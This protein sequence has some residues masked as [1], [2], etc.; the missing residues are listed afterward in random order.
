MLPHGI[1]KTRNGVA[2]I[3]SM[4]DTNGLPTLL[5]YGVYVGEVVVPIL[6]IIGL[7]T[8]FS[9]LIFAVNMAVA[10]GLAHAGDLLSLNEHG[11]WAVELPMLYL[12]GAV[13]ILFLGPGRIAAGPKRGLLA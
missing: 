7:L 1:A 4:L 11:G 5:A 9:A 3:E 6:L 12:L 10:I 8:R 13:A 2:G